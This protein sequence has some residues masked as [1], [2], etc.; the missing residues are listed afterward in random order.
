[1]T[2]RLASAPPDLPRAVCPECGEGFWKTRSDKIFC[3]DRCKRA[4][5]RRR[6]QRGAE[7]Y[8]AAYKWRSERQPGGFTEFC[9][10]VDGW[11][12]EDRERT[13][14]MKKARKGLK[15]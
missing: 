13:R 11:I 1:M 6:E 12:S 9:R 8:D 10:I 4:W 3:C 15:R 5:N 14:R 2:A 7:L